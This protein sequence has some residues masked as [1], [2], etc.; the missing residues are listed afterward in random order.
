M[1]E[2]STRLGP[3]N[4]R[5]NPK[6]GVW[7]FLGGE[8][9]FFGAL[10]LTYS[11]L[12]LRSPLDFQTAKAHLSIPLIG[13]NTFV[14]ILSSYFVVKS[15]EAIQGGHRKAMRNYL[16]G[17]MLLGTLFLSGQAFEWITLRGAGIWF[18]SIFGT[19]FFTITGIHGAH[20]LVGVVWAGLLQFAIQRGAITK[21]THLGLETFGL[22]WHFVDVVWIILFTLFY[23]I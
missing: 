20:V 18:S 3:V 22:Y 6:L 15:L 8:V 11:L 13:V 4:R 9:I 5:Q 21:D 12:R 14:L 1:N 23:L 7:I 2:I 16:I 17:V 10:I 19:P